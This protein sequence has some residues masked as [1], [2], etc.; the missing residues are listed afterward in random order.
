MLARYSSRNNTQMS[1]MSSTRGPSSSHRWN[2]PNTRLYNSRGW[3]IRKIYIE[4]N[5]VTYPAI[6][7]HVFFVFGCNFKAYLPLKAMTG[8]N[9]LSFSYVSPVIQATNWNKRKNPGSFYGLGIFSQFNTDFFY[10][11]VCHKSH[12]DTI[13]EGG[14]WG[15]QRP[16]LSLSKQGRARNGRV[17]RGPSLLVS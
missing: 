14:D 9:P 11:Y 1:L 17:A 10:T 7:V 5:P 13:I 12:R 15:A 8:K 16:V 6:F 3:T 4:E 2:P